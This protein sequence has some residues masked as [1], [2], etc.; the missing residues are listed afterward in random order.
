MN[1]QSQSPDAVVDVVVVVVTAGNHEKLDVNS[2]KH[3]VHYNNNDMLFKH[4][5]K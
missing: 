2:E 1:H 4:L 5:T 3:K